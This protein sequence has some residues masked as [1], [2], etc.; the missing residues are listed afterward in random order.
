MAFALLGLIVFQM[1]WLGFTVW[2]KSDQFGSDVRDAMQQVVRKL[3]Q[4]EMYYFMQ[5]KIASEENKKQLLAI[6]KPSETPVKIKKKPDQSILKNK[7]SLAMNLEKM[8]G[9]TLPSDILVSKGVEVLPNGEI[10]EH[11][12]FSI[13]L[14][15]ED[16]ISFMNGQKKLNDIFGEA[17]QRHNDLIT[18]DSLKSAKALITKKKRDK[19]PHIDR[20]IQY[21]ETAQKVKNKAEMAKEVIGDF[22]TTKRSIYD[23]INYQVLDSLLKIEIKDRG[24]E[25]PFEYGISSIENPSYLHYASSAKYKMTGLKSEKDT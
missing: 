3:S 8:G 24:I 4:Q 18:E 9:H 23:R 15:E 7:P 16:A 12:E 10:R 22:L 11:Q 20:S 21:A 5:R 19:K 2:T 1:F 17:I 13:D 25:I 14:N 6:A